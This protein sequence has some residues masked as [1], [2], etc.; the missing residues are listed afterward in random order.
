MRD[1]KEEQELH[2]SLETRAPPEPFQVL[3]SCP[4]IIKELGFLAN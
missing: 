3:A 4:E 2:P 1:T